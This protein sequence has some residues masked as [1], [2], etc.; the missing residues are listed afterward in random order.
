MAWPRTARRCRQR[1]I[2][3][4]TSNK[5]EIESANVAPSTT[6][7]GFRRGMFLRGYMYDFITLFAPH[8]TR[9]KVDRIAAEPDAAVRI[10]LA[11]S[12][13]EKLKTL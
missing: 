6:H 5:S 9:E 3:S 12:F 10:K 2:G 13:G 11:Q 7:I 1:S 4:S 8:L